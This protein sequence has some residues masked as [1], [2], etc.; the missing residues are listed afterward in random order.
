MSPARLISAV[1]ALIFNHRKA[2]L[3]V[4]GAL[5]LLF[6]ASASRL[7]VDAGFNK[8]VPLEH[9]YMQ[10]YREYEKVFGGA[11]RVAIAL[12]RKDGDIYDAEYMA[13]L[14]NLTSDLFLLKGVDRPTV[15]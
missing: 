11:N 15:K 14:K 10:V 7:A 3:V 8:M 12:M 5:T 9:P 4:F 6:A 2:W 13:A 1:S